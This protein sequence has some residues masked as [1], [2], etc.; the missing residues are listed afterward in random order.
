MR[1]REL[2]TP[3]PYCVNART[4]VSQIMRILLDENISAVMVLGDDGKLIGL[5]SEGDLVRRLDSSHQKKIDHWLALLAEGEALNLEFLHSLQLGEQTA[6]SVMSSP[7]IT[8]DDTA[9]LS[10]IA[11][12]LLKRGIKRV[13]VTRDGKLVGVVSRRDI[14][15]ALLAQEA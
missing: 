1:A 13:P 7:V 5:V 6:A 8:V 2:M 12:L 15:R 11:E 9:D 4:P 14:L 3:S 10:A